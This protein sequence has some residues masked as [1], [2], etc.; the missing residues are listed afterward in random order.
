MSNVNDTNARSQSTTEKNLQIR[1]PAALG[2]R[3]HKLNGA[4][5]LEQS[6]REQLKSL[7][8]S[9]TKTISVYTSLVQN[10]VAFSFW[11]CVKTDEIRIK[12]LDFLNWL[13]NPRVYMTATSRSKNFLEGIMIVGLNKL[14]IT[15]DAFESWIECFFVTLQMSAGTLVF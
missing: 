12:L 10:E 3:L 7:F 11:G 14:E 8:S 6:N 9:E 5:K 2:R 15:M 13:F 1:R 4:L